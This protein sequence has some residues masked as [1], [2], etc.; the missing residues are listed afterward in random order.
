M[1][2]KLLDE[3]VGLLKNNKDCLDSCY[4]E[5]VIEVSE[6]YRLFKDEETSLKLLSE[7]LAEYK[8]VRCQKLEE[9]KSC[10]KDYMYKLVDY[11]FEKDRPDKIAQELIVEY[12]EHGLVA[13]A[14]KLVI[15][16]NDL[17]K[18]ALSLIEIGKRVDR[19]VMDEEKIWLRR[20]I[21]GG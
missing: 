15:D 12:A 4:P 2:R 17:E 6:K 5:L 20:I 13:E 7:A 19:P 14:L 10:D 8:V 9:P 18:Q 11:S 16:I 3:T 1:S 21:Y